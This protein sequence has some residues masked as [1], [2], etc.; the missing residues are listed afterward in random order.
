MESSTLKPFQVND[1]VKFPDG[2][3]V[4]ISRILSIFGEMVVDEG[5]GIFRWRFK[6]PMMVHASKEEIVLWNLTH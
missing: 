4:R 5:D 2:K 6:S 3:I 1:I